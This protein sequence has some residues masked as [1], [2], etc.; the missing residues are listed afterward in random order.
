MNDYL[1]TNKI[2]LGRSENLMERIEPNSVALSFWSPP[3]FVG[4]E[5]ELNETYVSW[6]EMLKTVITL[7]SW[8]NIVYKYI[9]LQKHGLFPLKMG[10]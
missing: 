1:E 8:E 10:V 3:Y 2:Y 6:Q 7:N 4:K 9:R 5:Y